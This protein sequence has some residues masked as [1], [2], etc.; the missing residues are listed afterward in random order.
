MAMNVTMIA[1]T[2][3][4][5]KEY[6]CET[7][8]GRNGQFQSK[9]IMFSMA[10]DRKYRTT[11]VVN[12]QQTT[13]NP[14]DFFLVEFVGGAADAMQKHATGKKQDGK[15]QSRFL[16]LEGTFETYRSNKPIKATM[17]GVN[18]GGVLYDIPGMATPD[19][20]G[21][22]N[23]KF[24]VDFF[25]FLD[26][27]P[28]A[29]ES[30][31]GYSQD[32]A[33]QYGAPAQGGYAP[34]QQGY[35]PVQQGAAPAQQAAPVAYQQAPAQQS[36]T[37]VQQNA[38]PVQAPAAPVGGI[39]AP[40][41]AGVAPQASTAAPAPVAAPVA[42]PQPQAPANGGFTNMMAGVAQQM[43]AEQAQAG[44]PQAPTVPA[45]YQNTSGSA[46]F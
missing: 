44:A 34:V 24:V 38:V 13:D 37:P 8:N 41:A 30:V 27:N 45:G 7:R 36:Y 20:A 2:A 33:V 15:L 39:P 25:K 14:T 17:K 3:S 29:G 19:G 5:A 9:R 22:T 42:A 21:I 6:T 40:V 23:V 1:R 12:G 10:V 35:A 11:S 46:P 43:A 4:I 31:N 28:N 26:A 32:G 18:M 16:Y